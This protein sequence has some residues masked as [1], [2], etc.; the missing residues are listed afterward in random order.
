MST[1]ELA[2]M[3]A[4]STAVESETL[5]SSRVALPASSSTFKA[6]PAG[7]V[8]VE[9]DVPTGSVKPAGSGTARIPGPNSPEA[10]LAAKTGNAAPQMPPVKNIKVVKT[11]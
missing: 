6:A 1:E 4:T 11:Q 3:E 10:R 9:Y 2:Q 8:Y 7:T 5:G